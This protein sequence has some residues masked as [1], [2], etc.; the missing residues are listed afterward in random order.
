MCRVLK[1]VLVAPTDAHPDLRRKLSALDY[2]IVAAFEDAKTVD[3]DADVAV[4]WEPD[5][6]TVERLRGL[7]VKVVALGGNGEDADLAIAREDVAA[8]KQRVWELFRA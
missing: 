1:I 3:V 7:G 8:F 6:R 4:V 2:E 5:A